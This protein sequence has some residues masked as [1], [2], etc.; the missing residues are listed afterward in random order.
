M[1][2]NTGPVVSDIPVI[3][4]QDVSFSWN[5]PLIIEKVGIAAR[6]GE[7]LGL[8]G[9]NG[10]GKTTLL[11]L[12]AGLIEPTSGSIY[13]EG[14]RLRDMARREVARVVAMVQQKPAAEFAFSVEEVVGMGRHPHRGRFDLESDHDRELI[15]EAMALTA[16][17][18][19]ADRRI[20]EIS[21]GEQQRVVLARALA[22]EAKLLLL[23]EPTSNLDPLHQFQ[24]LQVLRGQVRR[25]L[26]VVASLHDLGLASRFCDRLVLLKHGG[27][28]A[29][30]SPE[31][32]LLPENLREAFRI[33]ARVTTDRDTGGMNVT[34]LEGETDR[35]V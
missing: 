8:I 19:L 27:I 16:T 1:D 4:V 9:P 17:S 24:V 10:A 3:R 34:V 29:Q 11:R 26:A 12:M 18:D 32:V 13:L 22:Q 7:F 2:V 5:G 30:G 6:K 31:Q 35:M 21:G 33:I 23:D 20:T 14:R 15:Q 28:L 25:G